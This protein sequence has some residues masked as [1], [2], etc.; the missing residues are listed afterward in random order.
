MAYSKEEPTR[1]TKAPYSEH[2]KRGFAYYISR[3]H[4]SI[5]DKNP[6]GRQKRYNTAHGIN[7]EVAFKRDAIIPDINMAAINEYI[8][9]GI[10]VDSVGV[11]NCARS[12]NC[13]S[14]KTNS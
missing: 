7:A 12:E 5:L 6:G 13:H 2:I 8:D 3:Q 14:H 9:A 4:S 10:R 1:V 11:A